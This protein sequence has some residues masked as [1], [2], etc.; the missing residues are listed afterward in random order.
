M[1]GGDQTAALY[2]VL[3]SDQ[4]LSNLRNSYNI[5]VNIRLIN[6]YN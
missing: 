1:F 5:E 2:S 4:I 3:Y 6:S